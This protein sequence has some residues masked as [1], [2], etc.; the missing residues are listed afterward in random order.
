MP[1][2]QLGE[3]VQFS[4]ETRR[5]TKKV[6]KP[7]YIEIGGIDIQTGD[8]KNIS[9]KNS[10]D[11]P[12]SAKMVVRENDILISKVRPNRG[13]ICFIDKHFDIA[14]TGFAVIR[15]VKDIID[16]KY[17]LYALKFGSTL[18]QFEQRSTGTTYPTITKGE[19]QKVLIPL[20]P[21]EIQIRIIALMDNACALRKQKEAEAAQI[22]EEAAQIFEKAKKEVEDRLL[23]IE[24]LD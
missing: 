10:S 8:I 7:F 1:H 24:S 14:T 19:L 18:K 15:E 12:S 13:A 4:R 3:L 21:K 6:T 22:F 23:E 17:L 16:R 20:P 9:E 5:K 11:M 2:K